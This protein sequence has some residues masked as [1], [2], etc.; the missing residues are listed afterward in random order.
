MA[1]LERKGTLF[2]IRFRFGGRKLIVPL[3]T[4]KEREANS[5]LARFEENLRLAERGRLVIPDDADVGLFLLSDGKL[6]QRPTDERLTESI[7]LA[8]LFAQYR[9]N[10][11]NG[12]K[13][14]ITRYTE[15][16]HI[17]HLERLIGGT[18]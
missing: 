18:K 15:R 11:P 12:A 9:A 4:E 6:N 1:W 17:A 8:E 7:T 10:S 2:R 3:R 13:E 14:E 5:C 16:I